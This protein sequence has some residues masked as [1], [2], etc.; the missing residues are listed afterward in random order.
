MNA[1]F[2]TSS[3]SFKVK[4]NRACLNKI[5]HLKGR[6]DINLLFILTN[7]RW[8]NQLFTYLSPN[9]PN[10]SS[11]N[12]KTRTFTQIAGVSMFEINSN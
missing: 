4:D 11:Q 8:R 7:P 1:T 12:P 9:P 3:I 2:K 6:F 5:P 10:N